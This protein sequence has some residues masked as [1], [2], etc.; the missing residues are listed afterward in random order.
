MGRTTKDP[1]WRKMQGKIPDRKKGTRE[2]GQNRGG[3]EG[4]NRSEGQ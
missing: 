2:A 4:T 3:Y 1:P